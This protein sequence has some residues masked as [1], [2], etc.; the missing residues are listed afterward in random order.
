[1][2]I[3]TVCFGVFIIMLLN[4]L[5]FIMLVN[6][7]VFMGVP[8]RTRERQTMLQ[9]GG[10]I[11]EIEY[12]KV[13]SGQNLMLYFHGNAGDL[14]TMWGEELHNLHDIVGTS[15]T[16]VGYD[17]RGYGNSTGRSSEANLRADCVELFQHL[18]REF[19]TVVVYGRSLGAIPAIEIAHDPRVK[20]IFLETPLLGLG[21]V[22]IIGQIPGLASMFRAD[23]HNC[24]APVTAVIA[25]DDELLD[26]RKQVLL[27]PKQTNVIRVPTGHNTASH[28]R[29]AITALRTCTK[30]F[31]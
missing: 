21:C 16:V 13:G 7:L 10:G 1:M 3:V 2:P 12:M 15:W 31:T 22:R 24:T 14:H 8:A 18:A 17:Y 5:V 9:V 27:L 30:R 20:H 26:P 11:A 28:N 4:Q 6:Q 23:V 19:S 29:R 25:T